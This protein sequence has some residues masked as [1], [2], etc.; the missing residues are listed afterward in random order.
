MR[1]MQARQRDCHASCKPQFWEDHGLFRKPRVSGQQEWRE[2][3]RAGC[4]GQEKKVGSGPG[5]LLDYFGSLFSIL[6]AMSSFSVA[7][8]EKARGSQ[9]C[10]TKSDVQR[11]PCGT[12]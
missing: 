7:R 3:G 9:G 8:S 5:G 6:R 2:G 4:T 10:V 1:E 12:A 11:N